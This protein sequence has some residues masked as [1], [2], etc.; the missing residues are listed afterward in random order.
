MAVKKLKV[1]KMPLRRKYAVGILLFTALA[2]GFAAYLTIAR[3]ETVGLYPGSCLGG[4]INTQNAQGR[5]S[6]EP[7]ASADL[8]NESNSAVLKNTIAQIFCGSFNGNIPQDNEPKKVFLKFSWNM[9]EKQTYIASAST[10]IIIVGESFASS[11][12]DII[13]EP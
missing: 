6:L 11:T 10:T 4:W 7:G 2:I 3:A 8:F 12:P 13:S 5:P 9:V 1:K